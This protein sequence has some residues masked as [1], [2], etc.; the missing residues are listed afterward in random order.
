MTCTQGCWIF[1]SI[2]DNGF[3]N[4]VYIWRYVYGPLALVPKSICSG[5]SPQVSAHQLPAPDR[6]TPPA[7]S[8]F[9]PPV[10][11]A[12]P[13][14]IFVAPGIICFLLYLQAVCLLSRAVSHSHHCQVM[15]QDAV[16]SASPILCFP[17]NKPHF[18]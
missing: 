6:Q 11:G 12:Y 3:Q 1:M 5:L 8:S 13:Y 7:S 18:S 10:F 17:Q 4:L 9:I 2:V 14:S 15:E 16:S